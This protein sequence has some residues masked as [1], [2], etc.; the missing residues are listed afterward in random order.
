MLRTG[1]KARSGR[2]DERDAS[3]LAERGHGEQRSIIS[4][5][6]YVSQGGR[7]AL[8]SLMSAQQQ[9]RGATLGKSLGGGPMAF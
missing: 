4:V 1:A 3:P 2:S 9:V 6:R 5:E 7:A 8:V